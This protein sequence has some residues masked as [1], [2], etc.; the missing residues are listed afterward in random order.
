MTDGLSDRASDVER[1]ERLRRQAL[2]GEPSGFRLGVALLERRGVAA[3]ARAWQGTAPAP[4][5]VSAR[6]PVES[7]TSGDQLVGAL[8]SMALARMA[9]G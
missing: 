3:W 2:S 8:A 6:P 5:S 9:A 7:P 1:Y 4:A